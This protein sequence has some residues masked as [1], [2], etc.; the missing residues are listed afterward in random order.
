MLS[1]GDDY[2]HLGNDPRPEGGNPMDVGEIYSPPYLFDGDELAKRPTIEDAPEEL[3]YGAPFGIEAPGR[4][5][6]RAR[7]AGRDDPRRGHEPAPGGAGDGALRRRPGLDVRSPHGPGAA[8]PGYYML[9]VLDAHG[10]P[11]IARWVRVAPTRRSRRRSRTPRPHRRRPRRPRRFRPRRLSPE[12]APSPTKPPLGPVLPQ[13]DRTAPRATVTLKRRGRRLDVRLKLS[14]TGRAAVELRFGARTVK[15][16]LTFANARTTRTVTITPPR[17]LKKL[18]VIVRA[19]DAAGNGRTAT[20]PLVSGAVASRGDAPRT[21]GAAG[22][23]APRGS[24]PAPR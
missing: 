20:T 5:A 16:S 21:A 7:G 3:P 11:S 22:S 9:F 19:R 17:G 24:P 4:G 13:A 1:A 2:W 23:C 8:P 10:T 12:A 14:E 18:T 6:R 15:R